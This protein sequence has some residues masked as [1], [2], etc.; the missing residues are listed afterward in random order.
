MSKSKKMRRERAEWR[1]TPLEMISDEMRREN[2]SF[3]STERDLR[4]GEG[5]IAYLTF[6]VENPTY[7]INANLPVY[8]YL[9]ML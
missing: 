1:Y 2:T 6:I 9:G 5:K 3:L 4:S 7:P 8:T